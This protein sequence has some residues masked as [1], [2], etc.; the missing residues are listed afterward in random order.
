MCFLLGISRDIELVRQECIAGFIHSRK[1]IFPTGRGYGGLLPGN[2]RQPLV[3][4]ET[5][6][7]E[8]SKQGKTAKRR[9]G[10]RGHK[11]YT[12]ITKTYDSRFKAQLSVEGKVCLASPFAKSICQ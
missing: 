7:H 8:D 6:K 2:V 12:G 11:K 4:A 1:A 5:S 3:N 10:K 9:C